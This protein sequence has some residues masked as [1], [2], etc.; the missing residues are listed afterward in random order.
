ML[1]LFS[2]RF[3]FTPLTWGDDSRY[4]N[5]SQPTS[6]L[7]ESSDPK[8]EFE[9]SFELNPKITSEGMGRSRPVSDTFAK[10]NWET[11]E[12]TVLTYSN[13]KKKEH[14]IVK[15][16]NFVKVNYLTVSAWN[17]L[18]N[19]FSLETDKRTPEERAGHK[20]IVDL[21][22]VAMGSDI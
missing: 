21:K 2:R 18:G 15:E 9:L 3:D 17:K 1:N 12:L 4:L 8:K 11:P 14:R 19:R 22:H 7:D 6:A 5:Q 20:N 10:K 16:N 13:F